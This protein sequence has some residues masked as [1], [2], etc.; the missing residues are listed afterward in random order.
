MVTKKK[1]K[2]LKEVN[3]KKKAPIAFRKKLKM[4]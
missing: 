3:Q 4:L 2:N 1:I